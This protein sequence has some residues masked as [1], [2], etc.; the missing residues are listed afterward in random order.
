M[1]F[2]DRISR[3]WVLTIA[4]GV[5][6][7]LFL[8][9]QNASLP[10]LKGGLTKGRGEPALSKNLTKTSVQ[11]IAIARPLDFE[12]NRGQSVGQVK[13]LSR[14]NG[15]DLLLASTEI[16][17]V[18]YDVERGMANAERANAH[19][20]FFGRPTALGTDTRLR[21]KL[22][23]ANAASRVTGLEELPGKSH[24]F[25]GNNPQ[26]W[27]INVPHY[28][29]VKYEEIYPGI[30]LVFYSSRQQ[31]EFDFVVAP[32]ASSEIIALH[33]GMME[34][35]M[36]KS[37]LRITA[38]GDLVV[39]AG[40]QEIRFHK[41]RIYQELNGVRQTIAGGYVSRAPA[42]NK[43]EEQNRGQIGFQIA[44]YDASKPLVIDPVLSYSTYLGGRGQAYARGI[45]VDAAGNVYVAGQTGSSD[46][47]TTANAVQPQI[48]YGPVQFPDA[49]VLK[50]K[51]EDNSLIYATYLGGTSSDEVRGLTVDAVG[52]AYVTGS[53]HSSDFP[54]TWHFSPKT[55]DKNFPPEDAFVTKLSPTGDLL[56]YSTYLGG[57]SL[58][59]G[60]GIAVDA[61]GSA[62]VTGST[63][64]PDFPLVS[65]LQAEYGG[66]FVTKLDP[67]GKAL[68]YSTYLGRAMNDRG[69]SIAVDAAGSAYITGQ[70]APMLTGAV[71]LGGGTT[72]P[73]NTSEAKGQPVTPNFPLVNPVQ[74][75]YGG[76]H[77]D[78][79]VAKINSA[80]T[81]LVYSTYLGG[82][83]SDGGNGIAVD[84]AGNAYVVGHSF[85][86]FFPKHNSLPARRDGCSTGDRFH[87]NAFVVKLN[88][89][90][91]AFIYAVCLGDS[92][93]QGVAL[94]STGS[95]YV[96]GY[97]DAK[98]F[99]IVNPLQTVHRGGQFDVFVA[100]VN[101]TGK[102]LDFATYLGGGSDDH[103]FGIAVDA[104]GNIYV[105]GNTDSENFPLVN[106]LRKMNRGGEAFVAK[107]SP[108]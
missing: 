44:S 94:N 9:L 89:T 66:A 68:V 26:N 107:I 86:S 49:F 60:Y 13:F 56:V 65:S 18:L 62:Y 7:V 47:S 31:W 11:A 105:T 29:K 33:F 104:S 84:A 57:S 67:A 70:T 102:A 2:L 54:A 82:S 35:E 42:A 72:P 17:L 1:P 24:Y 25:L 106:P 51:P 36:P 88:P 101:P 46:F 39:H 75:A 41:P 20:L 40:S 21:I 3:V 48:N 93:G 34:G 37:S 5:S 23:G 64:S 92:V 99:P 90:G 108:R 27:K 53:T 76:G 32:G 45:A 97:T 61:S 55:A 71:Y 77:S 14:G 83:D 6:G 8:I 30:D 80:G 43:T 103:A 19:P 22:D 10:T 28:A 69:H 95:A 4:A 81:A 16:V 52:N 96:T 58:D 79:F 87:A 38:N 74:G 78:G 59:G 85:S 12:P 98:D 73:P 50:L 15:Y 63:L 100:Q 91:N